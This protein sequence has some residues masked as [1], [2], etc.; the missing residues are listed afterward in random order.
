MMSGENAVKPY[1]HPEL[2]F[3]AS[4]ATGGSLQ[5]KRRTGH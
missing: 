4:D 2:H 1:G 3:V 5:L